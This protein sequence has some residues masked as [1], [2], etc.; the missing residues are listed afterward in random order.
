MP[1]DQRIAPKDD[2][3]KDDRLDEAERDNSVLNLL[4][5]DSSYPWTVD[6]IVRETQDRL[7]T[8]DAVRRL[9]GA[10]LLHQLGEFVFPTRA[11]RRANDM[12]V[13]TV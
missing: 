2:L 13:G 10:G 9:A 7:S 6:E 8:E 12:G 5:C 4:F 3:E 1:N 11:A